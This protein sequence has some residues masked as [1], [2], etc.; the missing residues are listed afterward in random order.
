MSAAESGVRGCAW[1][2]R[3]PNEAGTA[4]TAELEVTK[5]SDV[6]TEPVRRCQLGLTKVRRGGKAGTAVAGKEACTGAGAGKATEGADVAD[7]AGKAADFLAL[8]TAT[9]ADGEATLETGDGDGR[10]VLGLGAGLGGDLPAGLTDPFGAALAA[11]LAV[12]SK[13]PLGEDL[14]VAAWVA[15]DFF[16]AA[17][18]V[19]F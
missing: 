19:F 7:G 5:S 15:V 11:G 6:I 17:V 2:G 10:A 16:L 8:G 13:A 1:A 12:F 4:A 9:L 14:A 3:P 18:G